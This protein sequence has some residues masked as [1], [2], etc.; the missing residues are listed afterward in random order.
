MAKLNETIKINVEKY[1]ASV[2]KD[3]RN[4]N[5]REKSGRMTED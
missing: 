1:H 5:R 2:I 4:V 3:G